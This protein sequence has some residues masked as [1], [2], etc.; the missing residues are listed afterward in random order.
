MPEALCPDEIT[1]IVNELPG[2]RGDING[3]TRTYRFA[4]FA[5]AMEFM[6]SAAPAIDAANHHPEWCNVYSRVSVTLRTHDAGHRVTHLDVKLA[7][8]LDSFAKNCPS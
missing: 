5:T 6:Y 7:K 4:D 1:E 3:L 8:L 2:W